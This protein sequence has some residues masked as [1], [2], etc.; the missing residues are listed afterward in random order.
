MPRFRL[1]ERGSVTGLVFPDAPSGWKT[2][3]EIVTP[4]RV[5]LFGEQKA[6]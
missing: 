4:W 6:K 1:Q 3:G 5:T 2:V